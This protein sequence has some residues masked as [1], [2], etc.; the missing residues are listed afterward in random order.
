M[1]PL[2]ILQLQ[3]LRGLLT[4]TNNLYSVNN[5]PFP[6]TGLQISLAILAKQI[7]RNKHLF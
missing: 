5:G 7:C 4:N 2:T 6:N 1:S 3:E